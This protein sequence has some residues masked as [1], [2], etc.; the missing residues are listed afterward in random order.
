MP[1]T[2]KVQEENKKE[3]KTKKFQKVIDSLKNFFNN[4]APLIIV[5][6][7]IIAILLIFISRMNINSKIYVGEIETSDIQVS[8]IHYF[9]NSDMNYFYAAPAV[10]T[11]DDKEVYSYQIGYFVV[12]ENDNYIEFASR[13]KEADTSVNLSTVI[14][15]LSAWNFGELSRS[16]YFF[17]DE[18][19]DNLSNLHFVVKASTKKD[20]EEADVVLDYPVDLTKITK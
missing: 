8:N 5:L 7:G 11:G 1:R 15:E 10:Y 14:D 18:V 2:K 4:P 13:S 3:V 9:I 12:D 19:I 20:V 16:D 6:I 17:T